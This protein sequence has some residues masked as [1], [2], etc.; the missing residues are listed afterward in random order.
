MKAKKALKRLTKIDL[1]LADVIDQYAVNEQAVKDHLDAARN[2]LARAKATVAPLAAPKK[3]AKS[4]PRK[5]AA[6]KK[7]TRAAGK[8]KAKAS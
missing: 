8:K 5:K 3:A 1:I 2:S 7:S 4:A 6:V